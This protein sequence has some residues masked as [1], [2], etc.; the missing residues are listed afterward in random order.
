MTKT[1][2]DYGIQYRTESTLYPPS[3]LSASKA[4]SSRHAALF[5]NGKIHSNDEPVENLASS[6]SSTT[7]HLLYSAVTKRYRSITKYGI[8]VEWTN[9]ELSK[10]E[11]H[12]PLS[13]QLLP[14]NS[15]PYTRSG[16]AKGELSR[17]LSTLL[18]LQKR[19]RMGQIRIYR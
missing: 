12:A 8:L 5:P 7:K 10:H 9:D 14:T 2:L 15:F 4:L 16:K 6:I 11:H 18:L 1:E 3:Q 13:S 19:I 17:I